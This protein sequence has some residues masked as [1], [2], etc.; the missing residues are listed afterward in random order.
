MN[1]SD[2]SDRIL[3]SMHDAMLDD[4]HWP[5][6]SRLIDEA[7]GI[8]GNALVVGRGQSQKDGDILFSMF[9]YRGECYPDRER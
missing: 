1:P 4:A 5:A 2:I 3:L 6:T 9:C 8:R 7:C